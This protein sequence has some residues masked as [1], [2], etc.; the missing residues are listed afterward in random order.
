MVAASGDDGTQ[1]GGTIP[2]TTS[3]ARH[4][5]HAAVHT[6]GLA[7]RRLN[8]ANFDAVAPDFHLVISAA[9]E[10]NAS[11]GKVARKI[12]GAVPA[13]PINGGE[14][15]VRHLGIVAVTTGNARS[16]HQV[17]TGREVRSDASCIINDAGTHVGQWA[18]EGHRS[19]Y[20]IDGFWV[21]DL[22]ESRMDGGF[23]GTTKSGEAAVW[24]AFPEASG[25]VE[26]D[27]VPAEETPAQLV[28]LGC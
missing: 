7:E 8:L 23:G 2:R 3:G 28:K 18:A 26:S 11:A 17:F 10:F 25:Q 16:R 6:R 21:R 4:H 1:M 5:S 9:Q 20:R 14:F 13:C 19:P 27:P 22:E 24:C 15:T 12:V